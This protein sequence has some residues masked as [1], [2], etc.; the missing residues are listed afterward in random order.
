MPEW[1][2][3]LHGEVRERVHE[4][5]FGNSDE[6]SC[7]TETANRDPLQDGRTETAVQSEEAI[8]HRQEQTDSEQDAAGGNPGSI[9]RKPCHMELQ[10]AQSGPVTVRPQCTGTQLCPSYPSSGK[11]PGFYILKGMLN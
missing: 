2:S 9:H 3:N 4:F 10:R 7:E 5:D 1:N 11:F 6:A 8:G